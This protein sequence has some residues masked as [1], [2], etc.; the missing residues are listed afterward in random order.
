MR[1]TTLVEHNFKIGDKVKLKPFCSFSFEGKTL[2]I[3]GFN[4]PYVCVKYEGMDE[5]YPYFPLL[6]D[7]IEKVSI[8][9]EQLMLFEI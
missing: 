3:T 7:E 5:N 4:D 1:E 6:P 2:T 9:G 8:K